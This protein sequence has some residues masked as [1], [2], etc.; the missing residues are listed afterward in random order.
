M[1]GA[2]P[3]TDSSSQNNNADVQTSNHL[4]PDDKRIDRAENVQPNSYRGILIY[5]PAELC[6]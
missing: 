5:P 4:D 1:I 6:A 2:S 3:L